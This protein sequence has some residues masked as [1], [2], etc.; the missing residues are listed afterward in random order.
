MSMKIYSILFYS[1]IILFPISAHADEKAEKLLKSAS[2]TMKEIRSLAGDFEVIRRHLDPYQEIRQRGKFSLMKPNYLNISGANFLPAKTSGQWQKISEATGYAANGNIFYTL[3]PGA[4]GISYKEVKA[5]ADGG[6]ITV[7]LHPIADFFDENISFINRIEEARQ[8][9]TLASLR[10][11]GEKEWENARYKI[12]EFVTDELEKDVSRHTVT[13]LYVSSDKLI[14]RS[15]S[16]EK[17][18]DLTS[19]TETILR[20][21]HTKTKLRPSDF[22][23]TL[24]LGAKAYVPPPLPLANGTEAPEL[25][26]VENSGKLV[27]L[28]DFRGKTV[29]LDFWAT[30]CHPCIKSFQ[31]T[32]E[33]I[34]SFPDKEIVVLAV[35]VWDSKANAANWLAKNSQFNSFIFANDTA[36][37]GDKSS[38]AVFQVANLPLQYV[39]SPSGKVVASFEGYN[40]P[41]KELESAIKNAK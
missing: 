15:I 36:D 31:H 29:I 39:I 11:L 34:K 40:G 4:D 38:T 27:K 16:T 8:R 24:P 37:A 3:L 12:L 19:E 35:N 7:S 30:W 20:N 5:N 17:V 13:Q 21:V 6:N 10:Y 23:Y 2:E 28:S 1:I 26:L 18:G 41:T 25:T 14:R 9:Q 32:A 33:T 22:S